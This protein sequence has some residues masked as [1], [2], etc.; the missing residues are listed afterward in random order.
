MFAQESIKVDEV[1]RE[2]EAVRAAIGSG[3][4]VARFVKQAVESHHATFTGQNPV[5][6]NFKEAPRALGELLDR[7]LRGRMRLKLGSSCR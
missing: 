2:L 3:V 6:I 1:R 5:R 4:D 7:R